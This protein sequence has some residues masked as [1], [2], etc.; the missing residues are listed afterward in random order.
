MKNTQNTYIAS[1]LGYDG[2][3]DEENE[4][5]QPLSDMT[6]EQLLDLAAPL[7]QKINCRIPLTQDEAERH[8]AILDEAFRKLE[9]LRQSDR[10]ERDAH[11]AERYQ[12]DI[13][14]HPVCGHRYTVPSDTDASEVVDLKTQLC[15]TCVKAMIAFEKA[16]DEEALVQLERNRAQD[17]NVTVRCE[18]GTYW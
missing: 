1:L 16:C 4:Q 11:L 14:I 6:P 2:T 5:E 12:A 13:T 8:A 3:E 18:D 9:A 17:R 10:N 7:V 15:P